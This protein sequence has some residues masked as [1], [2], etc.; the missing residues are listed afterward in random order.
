MQQAS[1]LL[2]RNLK[3]A[4]LFAP[5]AQKLAKCFSEKL[6]REKTGKCKLAGFQQGLSPYF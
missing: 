2:F 6:E 1:V 5:R 4:S 3:I